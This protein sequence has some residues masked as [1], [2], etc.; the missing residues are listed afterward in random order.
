MSTDYLS[1]ARSYTV[2]P[3][4]SNT[5]VNQCSDTRDRRICA[6]DRLRCAV[7]RGL[8]RFPSID[9]DVQQRSAVDRWRKY[10]HA[11]RS[12]SVDECRTQHLDT[13]LLQYSF[14]VSHRYCCHTA[15][16]LRVLNVA[17]SDSRNRPRNFYDFL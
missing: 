8:I 9:G 10:D 5:C 14:S 16:V 11:Q 2:G 3:I 17:F 4:R 1:R 6:I 12:L 15:S 13:V 7:G